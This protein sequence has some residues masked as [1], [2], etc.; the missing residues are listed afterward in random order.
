MKEL[1]F[2]K[3]SCFSHHGSCSFCHE[4]C[5]DTINEIALFSN[6]TPHKS[7]SLDI[8]LTGLHFI[9]IELS[10]TDITTLEKALTTNT[11]LTELNLTCF[12]PKTLLYSF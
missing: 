4:C 9:D 6:S 11:S 2:R 1:T 5:F 7:S 3:L 10:E 12:N 8:S